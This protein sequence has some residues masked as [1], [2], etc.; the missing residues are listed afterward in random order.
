MMMF[1][2]MTASWGRIG[3]RSVKGRPEM[4]LSHQDDPLPY[5]AVDRSIL[6]SC[7]DQSHS[8]GECEFWVM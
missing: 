7:L 3:A 8:G 1:S 4:R 6:E 2:A 5:W